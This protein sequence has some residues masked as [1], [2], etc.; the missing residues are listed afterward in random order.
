MNVIFAQGQG[1]DIVTD[2]PAPPGVG[3]VVPISGFVRC[4]VKRVEW[5]CDKALGWHVRLRLRMLW[6]DW[7]FGHA[8]G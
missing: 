2:L 4:R 1:P 8:T 3:D 6:R 7:L 5:R